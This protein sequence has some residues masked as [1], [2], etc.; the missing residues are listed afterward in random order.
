MRLALVS[1]RIRSIC[2][3]FQISW[4]DHL[5]KI[6]NHSVHVISLIIPHKIGIN[7]KVGKTTSIPRWRMHFSPFFRVLHR[8]TATGHPGGDSAATGPLQGQSRGCARSRFQWRQLWSP[9]ILGISTG[10]TWPWV[11]T[12]DAIFGWM[13]IYL[14]SILMFT[15][16]TGF[17]PI[18]TWHHLASVLKIWIRDPAATAAKCGKIPGKRPFLWGEITGNHGTHWRM[19]EGSSQTV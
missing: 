3:S 14:P 7:I 2:Y 13:N 5:I 18:T 17:W 11:K 1:L 12:Y 8:F 9:E 15:R 10:I 4:F 19:A 6:A 16:G